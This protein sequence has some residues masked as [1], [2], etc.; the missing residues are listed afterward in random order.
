MSKTTATWTRD[1]N[2]SYREDG[3]T[4]TLTVNGRRVGHVESYLDNVGSMLSPRYVVTCYTV[5]IYDTTAD[6]LDEEF[7]V[8]GRSARTVLAEAKRY[9]LARA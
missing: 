1:D 9:L 4:W 3:A 6:G 7:A 5:S 8:K 2:S